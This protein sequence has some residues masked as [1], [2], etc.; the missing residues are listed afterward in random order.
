MP[1]RNLVG[2]T[3]VPWNKEHAALSSFEHSCS[4]NGNLL[5]PDASHTSH[6]SRTAPSSHTSQTSTARGAVHRGHHPQP[7]PPHPEGRG[8][9]QGQEGRRARRRHAAA[10]RCPRRHLRRRPLRRL[11]GAGA[12]GAAGEEEGGS[13]ESQRSG[14]EGRR[15]GE[16]G[17]VT[18]R[19]GGGSAE[20]W[21]RLG[22]RPAALSRNHP[23]SFIAAG[24]ATIAA[25]CSDGGGPQTEVYV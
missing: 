23:S 13:G 19:Q 11:A 24:F 9:G 6:P 10:A 21:R 17:D 15:R 18:E 25:G 4:I 14:V 16:E 1:T 3:H 20:A 5:S 7:A 12:G 8:A 2:W 22:G